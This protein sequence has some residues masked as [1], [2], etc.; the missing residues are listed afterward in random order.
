MAKSSLQ[1]IVAVIAERYGLKSTEAAAF[2]NAFFEQIQ[3]G[4]E[5]DRLVKVRGLGTFKVQAVKSRESVNVNTG[6]RV[7]IVGHEKMA[8]TP[9][10]AMKEL[11]NRPFADFE[12]VVIKDGVDVDSIPTPA[13]E[14]TGEPE[15]LGSNDDNS[16]VEATS[17]SAVD[18][19]EGADLDHDLNKT[20]AEI[21]AD[22][23]PK[24]VET[25]SQQPEKP[26]E[27][28]EKHSEKEPLVTP[29]AS[30]ELNEMVQ[31][32]VEA[33][34]QQTTEILQNPAAPASQPTQQEDRLIVEMPE[35]QSQKDTNPSRKLTPSERFSQLMDG[36]AGDTPVEDISASAEVSSSSETKK[37]DRLTKDS[38]CIDK[39]CVA[40]NSETDSL[41]SHS[42]EKTDDIEVALTPKGGDVASETADD[43]KTK[44][45]K[46][47]TVLLIVV[48]ILAL[49]G[50]GVGGYFYYISP[51]ESLRQPA[52]EKAN[53]QKT[54]ATKPTPVADATSKVN[55]KANPTSASS[56][57]SQHEE[58]AEVK[59]KGTPG[60]IDLEKVNRYPALRYGAYRIV[61]VEKK[62][63]LRRGDTMEKLC[64]RTLGKDMMGYFEAINGKG[65]HE[66]GDTIL[67]PKVELRPEYRK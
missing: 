47:C 14:S 61:G 30:Q 38:Q 2:V 1:A 42:T 46:T 34:P 52:I 15:D 16:P 28:Q 19:A 49:A 55:E 25:I 11:V 9:D 56:A 33:A 57:T 10:N 66:V 4:L 44:S 63:V 39:E 40:L 29:D 3:A 41:M 35:S 48:S 12:T 37:G 18:S 58:D 53:N 45:R 6:E 62:V 8:F 24:S 65:R 20:E 5:Q 7:V 67:V 26:C 54:V 27:L 51:Q 43:A 17:S 50:M 23:D 21:E 31:Q 64:R 22:D 13:E 32:T 59:Q 60:S 36:D